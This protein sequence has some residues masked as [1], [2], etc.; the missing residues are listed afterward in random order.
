MSDAQDFAQYRVY[1]SQSPG[2]DSTDFLAAAILSA[3][4]NFVS[5]TALTE[6]T[7]YYYK[8]YVVDI[9]DLWSGSN[10]V[11]A[12]TGT[13]SSPDPV[14]L[15]PVVTVPDFYESVDLE[16]SQ[17]GATDFES[18][19]LYR[20]RE[21]IGRADSVLAAFVTNQ[22]GT[23][24]TDEPPF[25]TSSNTV[26][27]WYIMHVYDIAGNSSASDSIRV[28]LVDAVPPTVSGS[29]ASSDS[30]LIVSW[31]Q[32]DIPDFGSYRLLRDTDSNPTGAI[33]VFVSS[34]ILGYSQAI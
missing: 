32:P 30:S 15:Y 24:F 3:D 25:D 33:T 31:S 5:D 16:W 19:R 12:T 2:V 18:Y 8:V 9:T 11:S 26:S 29:V 23:M 27:F 1:R 4:E 10:E 28:Q 21:D 17:S 34:N 14:D 22:S 20:W 6:N 7:M 13:D